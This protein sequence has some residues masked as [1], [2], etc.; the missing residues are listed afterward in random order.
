MRMAAAAGIAGACCLVPQPAAAATCV[1]FTGSVLHPLLECQFSDPA[2]CIPSSPQWLAPYWALA[3]PSPS[4]AP[5]CPAPPASRPPTSA[6]S[7]P[8]QSP[9]PWQGKQ[10]QLCT[11]LQHV[12]I[13][14]CGRAQ[15]CLSD[16]PSCATGQARPCLRESWAVSTC[17]P[18][19]PPRRAALL[20]MGCLPSSGSVV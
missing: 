1:L 13:C 18:A 10:P 8:K 4:L 15:V 3:L 12:C 17:W 16:R 7:A 5:G 11:M 9:C 2:A 20:C 6:T 14:A 19:A